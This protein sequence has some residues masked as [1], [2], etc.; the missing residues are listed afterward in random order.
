MASAICA[1]SFSLQTTLVPL[2]DQLP[3]AQ[4]HRRGAKK[5]ALAEGRRRIPDHARAVGH[6][7]DER[8]GG[9]VAE[10]VEP[11]C[12]TS[13]PKLAD[14]LRYVLRARVYVR[15]ENKRLRAH[16]RDR[17]E[18]LVYLVQSPSVFGRDRVLHHEDERLLGIDRRAHAAEGSERVPADPEI[19]LRDEVDGRTANREYGCGI[20]P[21][22]TTL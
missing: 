21:I 2:P 18:R 8:L 7:L 11:V 16:R 13:L 19:R 4:R 10:E 20:L 3:R 9:K 17:V 1:G 14:P 15:P 5:A 22:A 6:Q 12:A